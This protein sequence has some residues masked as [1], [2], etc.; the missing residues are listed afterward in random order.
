MIVIEYRKFE[1]KGL[2]CLAFNLILTLNNDDN[3]EINGLENSFL[4]FFKK[5]LHR[6]IFLFTKTA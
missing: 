6:S 2:S 1:S 5:Q 3:D 4:S